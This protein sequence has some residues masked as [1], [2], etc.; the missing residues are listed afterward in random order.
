MSM[1][2]RAGCLR[3][4]HTESRISPRI[5][6]WSSRQRRRRSARASRASA[7]ST[8]RSRSVAMNLL[9]ALGVSDRGQNEIGNADAKNAEVVGLHRPQRLTLQNVHR[10]GLRAVVVPRTTRLRLPGSL[11]GSGEPLRL[12]L[13]HADAGLSD[14]IVAVV[15]GLVR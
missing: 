13:S 2:P 6:S 15:F 8:C 10:G 11:A 14:L 4:A 3:S 9:R 5:A 12:A 1:T 7:S